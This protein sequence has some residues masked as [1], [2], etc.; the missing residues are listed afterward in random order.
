MTD[1]AQ[2]NCLR[3]GNEVQYVMW[4]LHMGKSIIE[5]ERERERDR[6]LVY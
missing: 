3:F 2:C 4:L 6:G 1:R 5:R